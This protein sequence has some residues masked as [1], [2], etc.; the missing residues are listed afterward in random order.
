MTSGSAGTVKAMSP[1][2]AAKRIINADRIGSVLNKSD[3][4]HRAASFLTEKN[5]ASSFKIVMK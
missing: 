3:L 5:L 4:E 2:E 1:K